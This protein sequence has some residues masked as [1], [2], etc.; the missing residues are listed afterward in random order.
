[1]VSRELWG[2]SE[3]QRHPSETEHVVALLPAILL[4]L[5]IVLELRLT[6]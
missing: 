1:V 3:L 4:A 5:P 6:V 2:C